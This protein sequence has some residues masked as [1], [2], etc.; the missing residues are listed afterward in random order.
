MVASSPHQIGSTTSAIKPSIAK[1]I[2]KIFRSISI[3]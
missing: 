2:Q 3:F 1:Q